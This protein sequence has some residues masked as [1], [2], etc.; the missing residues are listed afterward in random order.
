VAPTV[1]GGGLRAT[2]GTDE[3]PCCH[4]LCYVFV[5]PWLPAC[6]VTHTHHAHDSTNPHHA[7]TMYVLVSFTNSDAQVSV[8][9]AADKCPE[10]RHTS[11][12]TRSVSYMVA[13]THRWMGQIHPHIHI[14]CMQTF[15]H[16]VC[17]PIPSQAL[18]AGQSHTRST[19]ICLKHVS[20]IS[21]VLQDTLPCQMIEY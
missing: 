11:N 18:R 8:W 15:R 17:F 14:R 2:R 12:I 9:L 13:R 20:C 16:N 3:H 19:Y 10:L 1:S 5:S 7:R 6:G 21:T 4:L